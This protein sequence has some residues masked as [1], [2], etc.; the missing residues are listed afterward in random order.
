MN[1]P[2]H[3]AAQAAAKETELSK[4]KRLI[5]CYVHLKTVEGAVVTLTNRNFKT[6]KDLLVYS[7]EELKRLE[8][9]GQ[10][11]NQLELSSKKLGNSESLGDEIVRILNLHGRQW[12]SSPENVF[13]KLEETLGDGNCFYR[14]IAEQNNKHPNKI[15]NYD[16]ESLR[17]EVVER[18]QQEYLSNRESS[19]RSSAMSS[20]FVSEEG[21]DFSQL[22]EKQKR[23]T[24]YASM[25]F[26]AFTAALLGIGIRVLKIEDTDTG[27]TVRE[28]LFSPQVGCAPI[29]EDKINNLCVGHYRD[30]FQSIFEL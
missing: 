20:L 6:A 4:K 12:L 23:L 30:H 19:D 21:E 28:D 10:A 24:T 14:A 13:V 2:A 16:H 5:D 18:V 7:K 3:L 1:T 26:I 22:I 8:Q 17:S 11:Q 9:E 25:T 29:N 27:P 15:K